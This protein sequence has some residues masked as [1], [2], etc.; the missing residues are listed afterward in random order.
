MAQLAMPETAA[1]LATMKKSLKILLIVGGGLAVF[2][3][4]LA[5]LAFTPAVQTWAVRHA[6]AGTPGIE[7]GRTAIG[8]QS[9]Q[10]ENVRVSQPGLT[11]TLPSADI[12]VPII[13]G[14]GGDLQI[15]RLTAKGWTIDLS[16]APGTPPAKTGATTFN[17]I[18]QLLRLP[19]TLALDQADLEGDLVHAAD[20]AHVVITGGGLRNGLEGS[21][22]VGVTQKS[23]DATAPVNELT[24]AA[25]VTV[26][27][28]AP[29]A[30]SGLTVDAD[31]TARGPKFPAGTAVHLTIKTQRTVAG[32]TYAASIQ[33][34]G[35]ELVRLAGQLAPDG[36]PLT[37]QWNL[38]A[39][40]T[41]FAPFAL[42]LTYT[43]PEF[44]VKGQGTLTSSRDFKEL[45]AVGK[46]TG[47]VDKLGA[48]QPELAVLG[49]QDFSSEFDAAQSGDIV[50]VMK[51]VARLGGANP[52]VGVET[53]QAFEFNAM[54][55]ETKVANVAADLLNITLQDVPLSWA[56]PFI[57]GLKI[58]GGTV[59]GQLQVREHNG[60]FEVHAQNL[61]MVGKVMQ[62]GGVI[63][64]GELKA[65]TASGSYGK[66][67]WQAEVPLLTA[68][69]SGA[70]AAANRESVRVSQI[71]TAQAAGVDQP[72]K[73]DANY[74]VALVTIKLLTPVLAPHLPVTG[75]TAAG[76]LTTSLG[77]KKEIALKL[78]LAGVST[79]ATTLPLPEI[80]LDA[81]TDIGADG[82]ITANVP[83]TVIQGA[84]KSDLTIGGTF[85]P[86]KAGWHIDS[87]AA[88]DTLYIEDLNAF[89]V[90]APPSSQPSA[91]PP[92]AGVT[93]TVKFAV[94]KVVFTPE[95]ASSLVGTLTLDG[96][97]PKLDAHGAL[98]G[99]VPS[100]FTVKA[101]VSHTPSG[102]TPFAFTADATLA[103]YTLGALGRM[104]EAKVNFDIHLTS[105]AT[106]LDLLAHEAQGKFQL[107]SKGGVT[108]L[109]A[110]DSKSGAG[111]VATGL[112]TVAGLAGAL[113]GGSNTKAGNAAKVIAR[114]TDLLREIRFDQLNVSLT[115]GA[116][117]DLVLED[118]TLIAPEVRLVGRG[119]VRNVAGLDLVAQPMSLQFQVAA[120]GALGE[121]M[122][123]VSLVAKQPDALGYFP[124]AIELPEIVGSLSTPDTGAFYRTLTSRAVL[125]GADAAIDGAGSL[126]QG[127]SGLLKGVL[128]K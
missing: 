119:R 31:V 38:D 11:F 105:R 25:V 58:S 118:F 73:L 10:V 85:T 54:T 56:Q 123:S 126:I 90:L 112:G 36:K 117:Q 29:N 8:L 16:T 128:G 74:D 71:R 30:I 18:F 4:A 50:R 77:A 96:S 91:G 40:D 27:M 103:D 72:L 20:H 125:V 52:V 62:D 116:S 60:N 111:A 24:L 97:G 114:I 46:L 106:S 121:A 82:R 64:D 41:D 93:G 63:W 84:Q 80:L 70:G 88:G 86:T 120:R 48:L 6:L 108:R 95:R 42:A 102:T 47:S 3:A 78:R 81:R 100:L 39:T 43:L 127:A 113:T 79:A 15:A 98:E 66:L 21:F 124:L 109:L 7:V 53:A 101:G 5:A 89:A 59:R 13:A 34:G 55:K 1:L 67:G 92:W 99:A 2:V 12:E 17:G 28:D 75:G 14:A 45:A 65:A 26:A 32:E 76:S 104:L 44:M 68:S 35:R 87:Q 61:G 94:K 23:S 9:I 110:S 22:K 37:G 49:R 19:F 57:S 51:L 122:K 33:S 115:R 83:V 69:P 107:S